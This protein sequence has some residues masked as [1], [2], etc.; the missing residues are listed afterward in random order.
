MRSKFYFFDILKCMSKD[1]KH[2]QYIM[3]I[4]STYEYSFSSKKQLI[5][6]SII[7]FGLVLTKH[8]SLIIYFAQSISI[9]LSIKYTNEMRFK[10]IG[11]LTIR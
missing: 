6:S 9:N 3:N 11:F 10:M 4:H 5:Y 8:M 2:I 1:S 7:F